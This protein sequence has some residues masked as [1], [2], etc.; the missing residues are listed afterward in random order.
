MFTHAIKSFP[1]FILLT[2]VAL[3][4][5]NAITWIDRGEV[6]I[7]PATSADHQRIPNF[8]S[9]DCYVAAASA[10]DPQEKLIWVRANLFLNRTK[11]PAGEPLVLFVSG[12]MASAFYLNGHFAGQNGTPGIDFA[13][14]QPGLMDATLFPSQDSFQLGSNSVV[15]LASAHHGTIKLASPI[16][17][18]AIGPAGNTSDSLLR[19]YWPSIIT[20][21][22]FIVG[23]IYFGVTGLKGMSKKNFLL[24]SL[25][26]TFAALQLSSEI[27]R[28]LMAYSYP[29]HDWR[30]L[31]IAFFS[32]GFG[33][34]VA[35]HVFTTFLRT[36]ALVPLIGI[37]AASA[38]A[39]VLVPGFD[40]K[41]LM[42]MLLPLIG[43]L[44]VAGYASYKR[45]QRAF[46][47]FCALLTFVVAIVVFPSLF[48]DT[49]FFYLVAALLL[50]LF[51]EQALAYAKETDERRI[52]EARANRLELAL[53]QARE[54]EKATEISVKSAGRL[55][56]IS[57]DQIKYCKGA[58]GY[59]E[60]VLMDGREI[61]H[62]VTLSE[63][64]DLL[65]AIFI[66]IHR[67][68]LVNT[69]FVQSLNRDV[70]GTG[71]LTLVDGSQLSVSRRT[72]PAVRKALS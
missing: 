70:T 64:E 57:A 1:C 10:I 16:H 56:R 63:M 55:E 26:C 54:R 58:G 20:L 66:R 33:L 31:A 28:G 21:G 25:V 13:T 17:M 53:E 14:E 30:L 6:T 60:I 49:I 45:R 12:K 19:H 34:T 24:L 7:C 5:A 9:P 52:E 36:N 11:G 22:L 50:F 27:L 41:S 59:T 51:V 29:L 43:S 71:S 8:S 46:G 65:P 69:V 62:A 42:A 72:M 18:I 37:A 47:Y 3:N 15:F 67:S 35:F 2:L 40:E 61:L 39:A 48:L 23:A 68:Y 38:L 4:P 32:A 44:A